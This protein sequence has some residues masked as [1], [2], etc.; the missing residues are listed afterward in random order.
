MLDAIVNA[1]Q[2]DEFF[3]ALAG[4]LATEASAKIAFSTVKAIAFAAVGAMFQPAETLPRRPRKPA[5]VALNKP[6]AKQRPKRR[7]KSRGA[8]RGST[9]PLANT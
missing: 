4:H 3:V 2:I 9:R 7:A 6:R 8:R 5:R 1:I